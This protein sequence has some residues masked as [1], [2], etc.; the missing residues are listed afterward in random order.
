MKLVVLNHS[1]EDSILSNVSQLSVSFY[2]YLICFLA[3]DVY[4]QFV[5]CYNINIADTTAFDVWTHE[6]AASFISVY[7]VDY[8]HSYVLLSQPYDNQ[9]L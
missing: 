1:G 6:T 4:N 2:I 3:M 7:T 8:F 5:G 9:L